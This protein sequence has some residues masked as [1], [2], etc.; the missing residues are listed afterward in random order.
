MLAKDWATWAGYLKF[1][2]LFRS[3]I[4]HGPAFTDS[5]ASL[6]NTMAAQAKEQY[7]SQAGTLAVTGNPAIK[8]A[9]DTA[10][11]AARD[12]L[13]AG[14]TP[15]TAAWDRGGPGARSPPS[16]ARPGCCT[17]SPR[18]PASSAPAAGT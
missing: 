8:Q 1:G 3:R 17:G 10:V 4:P 14:L 7:Y 11:Q 12:G 18:W 6:Y 9:W 13:S 16:C 2:R 5:A 15:Q